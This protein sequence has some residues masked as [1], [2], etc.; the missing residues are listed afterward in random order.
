MAPNLGRLLYHE[1][2]ERQQPHLTFVQINTTVH[3]TFS[4]RHTMHILEQFWISIASI[5]TGVGFKVNRFQCF[6]LTY[7]LWEH[8]WLWCVCVC[9]FHLFYGASANQF[10]GLYKH[11][12]VNKQIKVII[13]LILGKLKPSTQ[14]TKL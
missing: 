7:E 3:K 11:N 10:S 12:L 14:W 1:G 4:N 6:I 13:N 9:G 2:N 5:I 8:L